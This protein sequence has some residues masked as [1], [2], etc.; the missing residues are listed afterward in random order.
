MNERVTP[1]EIYYRNSSGIDSSAARAPLKI[2]DH[3]ARS[4]FTMSERDAR[5]DVLWE[6]GIAGAILVPISIAIIALAK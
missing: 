5:V 2:K 4:W 6:M 3:V 1:S